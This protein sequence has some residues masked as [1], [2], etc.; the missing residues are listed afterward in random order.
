[1]PNEDD[2]RSL[3]IKNKE[4]EIDQLEIAIVTSTIQLNN[5]MGSGP[6]VDLSTVAGIRKRREAIEEEYEVAKQEL[7]KL[8]AGNIPTDPNKARQSIQKAAYNKRQAV[9]E[10]E[11]SQKNND[12]KFQELDAEIVNPDDGENP[13]KDV[14]NPEQNS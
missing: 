7:Q 10:W 2:L 3:M 1:M 8:R 9:K 5:M 11:E 6:D 14:V 13:M 4:E 12:D